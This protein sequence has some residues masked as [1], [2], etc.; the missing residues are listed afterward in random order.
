VDKYI[1]KGLGVGVVYASDYGG[2]WGTNAT[3]REMFEFVTMDRKVVQA[4]VNAENE[5]AMLIIAGK[6]ASFYGDT[7]ALNVEFISQGEQFRIQQCDGMETILLLREMDFL[8]A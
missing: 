4:V 3:S 5:K 1:V 6:F 7:D 2:G 8:T